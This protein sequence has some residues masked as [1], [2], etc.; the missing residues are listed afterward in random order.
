MKSTL[1]NAVLVTMAVTAL[2][3]FVTW[4]VGVILGNPVSITAIV[5]SAALPIVS[6]FPSLC[7]LLTKYRQLNEQHRLLA[8]A[9][10]ELQ[11]RAKIDHMTGLLNRESLFEAVKIARSRIET[12]AFLMI[13]ADHFKAINDNF[14]HASGDRALKL[15]AFA[16]ENV[17]R[18]GDIVGRIGG[19]EFCVFLPNASEDTAKRVAER[20]RS[21]VDT[22]PFY[23]AEDVLSPLTVSIGC[24][25]APK[26]E[27]NSQILSRAD[28]ALYI[29]KKRGRNCSVFINETSVEQR[30]GLIE[31]RQKTA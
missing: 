14:G 15:I 17:T 20:I 7:I 18:K 4:L 21:E 16:I 25:I 24:T 30:G 12:G 5:L 28:Q 9:H 26:N 27:S 23:N 2:S 8:I 6:A 13:D 19:E 11:A 3:V 22:T 10:A 29:A 31:F 1:L